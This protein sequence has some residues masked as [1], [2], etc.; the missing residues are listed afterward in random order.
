RD[1]DRWYFQTEIPVVYSQLKFR[2]PDFFLYNPDLRGEIRGKITN[3]SRPIPD[4]NYSTKIN[5]FT[6]E[7]VKPLRKEPF[8]FNSN[9]L[10]A[11][12]RFELTMFSHPGFITENYAATWEQIGKDLSKHEKIG[13]QLSGNN[14]LDETVQGIVGSY[15]D[16]LDKTQAIFGFVK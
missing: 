14:F 9:N 2:H 4:R 16:P 13:G 1:I 11:S 10:K 3:S 5:E 7:N 6:F 15:A 8:V 12:V